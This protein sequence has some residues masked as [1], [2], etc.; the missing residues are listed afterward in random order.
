[1]LI[2]VKVCQHVTFL[3]TYCIDLHLFFEEVSPIFLYNPSC[4]NSY[5]FLGA[6]SPLRLLIM[7]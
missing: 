4:I 2:L 3:H 6:Y 1:M 7:K 5:R